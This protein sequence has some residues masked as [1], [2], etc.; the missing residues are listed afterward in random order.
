MMEMDDEP[1]AEPAPPEDLTLAFEVKTLKIR[2]AML[3][4]RVDYLQEII[5]N[6]RSQK[7]Q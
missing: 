7:P 6:L 5:A 4:S 1:K 2:V 3:E